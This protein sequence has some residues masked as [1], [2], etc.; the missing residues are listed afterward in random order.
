MSR[1]SLCVMRALMVSALLVNDE[2]HTY[3]IRVIVL[4][5]YGLKC[6]YFVICLSAA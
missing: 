3:C 1:V 4:Y 5:Y 2:T 6:G